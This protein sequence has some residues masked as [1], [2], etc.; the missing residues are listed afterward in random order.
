MSESVTGVR[1]H[2][3]PFVDSMQDHPITGVL[4]VLDTLKNNG[5]KKFKFMSIQTQ[6][7]HIGHIKQ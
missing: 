2:I 3:I 7:D 4:N 5:L 1:N 6:E